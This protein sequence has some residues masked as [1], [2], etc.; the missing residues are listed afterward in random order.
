MFLKILRGTGP[1][2]LFLIVVSLAAVWLG[3]MISP[4]TAGDDVSGGRQMILYRLLSEFTGEGSIRGLLLSVAL[5]GLMAYLLVY[6]NTV[7][8]FIN[9][10]TYIPAFVYILL[11]GLFPQNQHM[12]PALPASVFLLLAIMRIV[13]TYRVQGTAFSFFDAG[14]L[15][16]VGSLF[17]ANLV[18]SGLLLFVGIILIRNISLREIVI[19]LAGLATPFLICAGILY[20]TGENMTSLTED[21]KFNILEVIVSPRLTPVTIAGLI[22]LTF[23][24]FIGI[25]YLMT[26]VGNKKIKSRKAFSIFL[27]SLAISIILSSLLSSASLEIIWTGMI[28]SV[29]LISHFF[30]LTKKTL[31]RES[32]FILLVVAVIAIQVLYYYM[33]L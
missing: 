11:T 3:P 33:P 17:Y 8:F 32:L 12:N 2:V 14:F 18:W 15:I 10:R 30:V 7:E 25:T 1:G 23:Y 9:E 19:S 4:Q 13:K 27:W 31:L 20:V 22:V 5:T 29:Y 24:L 28:P 26:V 21:L 6:F 16:S